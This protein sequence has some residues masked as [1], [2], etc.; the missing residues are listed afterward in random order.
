MT[1]DLR[2]LVDRHTA[3]GVPRKELRALLVRDCGVSPTVLIPMP[4][5]R[6]DAQGRELT[7]RPTALDR[8]IRRRE[9]GVML[10][11]VFES[12]YVPAGPTYLDRLIQGFG[13]FAMAN[14][15]N[16]ETKFDAA[17][18]LM[19]R[20]MS[21]E[22]SAFASLPTFE[23]LIGHE[24]GPMMCIDRAIAPWLLSKRPTENLQIDAD[25]AEV[26]LATKPPKETTWIDD[27]C[28]TPFYLDVRQPHQGERVLSA[29]FCAP[30]EDGANFTCTAVVEWAG[31]G[32][33]SFLFYNRATDHLTI[34][35]TAQLNDEAAEAADRRAY[36]PLYQPL[37][38]QAL[39][40][41][42]VAR[43]YL[44]NMPSAQRSASELRH[45]PRPSA[46]SPLP[47]KKLKA[48]EKTHSYFRVVRAEL[49]PD[50]FGQAAV[51]R[52]SWSLDHLVSVVGHFRW[53]PH[54]SGNTKQ[55]L[56]W[57]DTYDKGVGGRHRPE[58][59]PELM[60]GKIP[61]HVH[62]ETESGEARE[63]THER[64]RS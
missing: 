58:S 35:P 56:I 62:A 49:P 63:D 37:M 28:S 8:V 44:R 33:E 46:S 38:E 61:Q 12:L 50:R 19:R 14:G 34:V 42:S 41:V 4:S 47:D 55:K 21:L 52:N 5:L 17:V 11:E 40:L 1:T 3:N 27:L 20:R 36:E 26:F 7:G 6:A 57:I 16:Y 30:N 39:H 54:G 10:S 45:L 23:Q 64:P 48:Q 25:L 13:R 59:N 15:A 22:A 51:R 31:R 60:V 2:D 43:Q 18:T 9:G 32:V 29:V 24:S 53:R